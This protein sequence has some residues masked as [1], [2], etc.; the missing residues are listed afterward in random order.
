MVGRPASE[1]TQPLFS[2]VVPTRNRGALLA[3]A[4]GSV[5]RQTVQSWELIVVDDSSDEPVAVP[6]DPRIRTVRLTTPAGQA[7]ARNAGVAAARGTYVA[8]LDDDDLYTDDRLEIALEGLARAPIATCW[9]RFVDRP[10]SNN[11]VLE[12]DVS[13]TILDQ[14]TPSVGATTLLR[15]AFIPFD[16]R[17]HGVEDVEWWL[18]IA[19][20]SPI[21]TVPRVGY[22][23]RR[24]RD[25]S[26]A[27]RRGEI[28][29]RVAENLELL[30]EY[31]DYF[32]SHPRAA[33]FRLKRVGLMSGELGDRRGACSA[34]LRSFRRRPAA[35][36]AWHLARSVVRAGGTAPR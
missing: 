19:A 18:R 36:T 34:L 35:S 5:V 32:R 1:G 10:P 27:P 13:D 24:W 16:T 14:S 11:V 29:V 23:F 20:T 12:G 17:W 30:V 9:M 6:D 31:A 25:V 2:V 15:S 7:S 33:A 3:E 28:E 4:I 22:L 8:F 21:A 26:E